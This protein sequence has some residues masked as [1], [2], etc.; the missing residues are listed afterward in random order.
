MLY[1]YLAE[2]YAPNEPIFPQDIDLNISQTNLRQK[3]KILCDSGKVRR[4]DTG[5]YYLPKQSRLNDTVPFT[6]ERIAD[7][8]Y[9]NRKGEIIGYYSGFT[10]ANQI[11]LTTQVP[12]VIEIT[13]NNASAAVREINL[14]GRQI[15]LRCSRVIVTGENAATLQLLDFMK[16]ITRYTDADPGDIRGR[17]AAYA[18]KMSI[19]RSKVVQYIGDYPD[20]TYRNLILTGIYDVLT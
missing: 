13:S 1:E 10:F 15:V 3:F 6:P 14:C 18:E 16:D 20:R 12:A 8:K 5:I 7:C 11:G 17:I 19:T 4:Y 9:V 2:N